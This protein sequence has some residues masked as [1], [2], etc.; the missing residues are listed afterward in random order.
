MEVVPKKR[1]KES[2]K[3]MGGRPVIHSDALL[4][5]IYN[6]SKIKGEGYKSVFQSC[7]DRGLSYTGINNGM[8]RIGLKGKKKNTTELQAVSPVA[9]AGTSTSPVAV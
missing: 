3:G 7:A 4:T 5:E 6:Q 9:P 8:R 2:R 1:Y